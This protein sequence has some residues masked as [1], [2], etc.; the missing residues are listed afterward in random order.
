MKARTLQLKTPGTLSWEETELPTLQEGQVLVES[1]YGAV[2]VGAE[3]PIYDGTVPREYP[4]TMG[5]EVLGRVVRC[6]A[7]VNKV[8]KGDQVLAFYGHADRGIADQDM[9]IPI[10]ADVSHKI[11]LLA[12]LSSQVVGGIRKVSPRPSKP[13]LISGAGMRGLFTLFVLKASN[14]E[15]VDVI[16]PR[17][18]RLEIARGL[19]ARFAVSPGESVDMGG[20]YPVA[21]ECTNSNDS[22][23]LLQSRMLPGGS[24]SIIADVTPGELVMGQEFFDR[25]LQV[26]ATSFDRDSHIYARW[27]FD[28]LDG[29]VARLEKIF[30]K[31]VS[32]KELPGEFGA[33]KASN[34]RPLR[35]LLKY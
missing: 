7:D 34:T 29:Y 2:D 24:I 26:F 22:F 10:P 30:E 6:G 18:E 32:A 12:G 5:W 3:V 31:E 20:L 25:D 33:M 15:Y 4:L 19:G 13:I 35:I 16:E 14:K 9:V 28:N 17:P 21:F 27:F 23:Q 8:K 1:E 11:A